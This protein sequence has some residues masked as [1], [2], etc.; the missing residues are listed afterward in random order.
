MKKILTEWKRYLT[1]NKASPEL[2]QIRTSLGKKIQAFVLTATAREAIYYIYRGGPKGREENLRE[3]ISELNERVDNL[4]KNLTPTEQAVFTRDFQRMIPLVMR[5][6]DTEPTAHPTYKFRHGVAPPGKFS[7]IALGGGMAGDFMFKNSNELSNIDPMHAQFFE[8]PKVLGLIH[9]AV[10]DSSLP[11]GFP[12]SDLT[13]KSY[14]YNYKLSQE[15]VDD[16]PTGRLASH[17][18]L[19]PNWRKK[20]GLAEGE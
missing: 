4:V 17:P 5:D 12:Y 3:A 2:Q 11:E 8:F 1:E 10:S 9:G 6:R 18:A 14:H 20:M 7:T 19:D 16:R 15:I 13:A